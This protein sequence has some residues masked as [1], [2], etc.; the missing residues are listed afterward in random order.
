MAYTS[1]A[2]Q[3]IDR[4]VEKREKTVNIVFEK[5]VA[6]NTEMNFQRLRPSL[7]A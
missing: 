5:V 3:I 1:L 4:N 2:K 7:L 6:R